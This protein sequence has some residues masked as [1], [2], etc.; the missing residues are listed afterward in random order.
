MELY[1]AIEANLPYVVSRILDDPD[2]DPNYHSND[3]QSPL[4]KAIFMKHTKIVSI[5]LN[6]PRTDV[7]TGCPIEFCLPDEKLLAML[8]SHSR[9]DTED[10]ARIFRSSV[11]SNEHLQVEALLKNSFIDP[12]LPMGNGEI[13]LTHSVS[14]GYFLVVRALCEDHRVDVNITCP[15]LKSHS[16]YMVC[17]YRLHNSGSSLLKNP[18][19]DVNKVHEDSGDSPLHAVCRVGSGGMAHAMLKHPDVNYNLRDKKGMTPLSRACSMGFLDLVKKILLNDQV[20]IDTRSDGNYTPIMY[21]AL[22]PHIPITEALLADWR[23]IDASHPRIL[24]NPHPLLIEFC[25][26]PWN[27][28]C[29]L[30]KK[31]GILEN[32]IVVLFSTVIL[33]ERGYARLKEGTEH[34]KR[35]YDFIKKLPQELKMIACCRMCGSSMNFI[36]DKLIIP[37]I[38]SFFETSRQI[39]N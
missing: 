28:R 34:L 15:V 13:P 30:W 31:G 14:K 19:I 36:Q 39:K 35:F 6:D 12:N 32:Q 7:N 11:V 10:V 1:E 27:F 17:E 33:M 5:L 23:H 21:S 20:L 29:G 8:A 3:T 9:I 24:E 2:C 4:V 38:I 26:H 25:K 16:L 18:K 22:F 37:K